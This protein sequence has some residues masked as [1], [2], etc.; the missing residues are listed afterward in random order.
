MG[1][2]EKNFYNDYAKRLGYE[3][4]AAK[5]QDLFLS[6]KKQEAMAAVPDAL[7]DDVAL[8]GSADRIRDRLQAWKEAGKQ[9]HVGSMLLG[10]A[11]SEALKVIAE[12]VL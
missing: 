9:K 4:A 8:V 1:A 3:E 7:V 11:N 6:G 12:E 5:I 10:G 2:R